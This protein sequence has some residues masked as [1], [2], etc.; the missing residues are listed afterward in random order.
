VL[1]LSLSLCRYLS[2]SL[3]LSLSISPFLSLS[4]NR[5]ER[6]RKRA[7][8]DALEESVLGPR[9]MDPITLEC[10]INPGI[11]PF[12]HVMGMATWCV[13]IHSD[14]QLA[15]RDVKDGHEAT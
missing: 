15:N 3:T 9:F 13:P 4:L 10:V 2:L 12:G 8:D 11:S 1:S 7:G 6:Y 14:A 5:S